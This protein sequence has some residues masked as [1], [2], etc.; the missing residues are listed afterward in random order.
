MLSCLS[1]KIFLFRQCW[2]FQRQ[3]LSRL[4]S[5]CDQCLIAASTQYLNGDLFEFRAMPDVGNRPA[6]F[7]EK[8]GGRNDDAVDNAVYRHPDDPPPS[9]PNTP[10]PLS[11][12]HFTSNLP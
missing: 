10:V 2:I 9:S 3:F 4:Q 5:L 12:R 11:H 7:P 8:C 1:S 6:C